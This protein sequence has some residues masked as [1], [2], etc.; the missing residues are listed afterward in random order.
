VTVRSAPSSWHS[1]AVEASAHRL[2]EDLRARDPRGGIDCGWVEQMQLVLAQF[3]S[4]GQRILDPFAGFGTTLVACALTGRVA[5]GIERQAHRVALIHERLA[6]YPDSR[7]EVLAGDAREIS[8]ADA[9]IDLVLTNLPYFEAPA[10][11]PWEDSYAAHLGML[12]AA[13]ARQRRSMK[14]GALFV[15]AAEN[16]RLDVADAHG[17]FHPS[18]A[19][20]R[21]VPFAWDVARLLGRH[22]TLCEE[23]LLVYPRE[24]P[25][26]VDVTATNRAH[27]YLLVGRRD[28]PAVNVNQAMALLRQLAA[29]GRFIVTGGFALLLV[30]PEALDRAPTD[31]D[32]LVPESRDVLELFV[33]RLLTLGFAVTSWGEPVSLPLAPSLIEGRLYLRAIHGGLTLDLTFTSP[34]AFEALWEHAVTSGGVQVL[35]RSALRTQLLLAGRPRDLA[36]AQALGEAQDG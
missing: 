23:Q 11:G 15:A 25:A 5:V 7:C 2:P 16:L 30:A 19:R 24:R 8:A 18:G 22:L 12:D 29:V 36:R 34:P 20:G 9:S 33:R 6:R 28:D 32:I 27:E 14:S 26:S 1:L 17:V 31:V 35:G 13:F 3:S 21:F 10:E 4:A